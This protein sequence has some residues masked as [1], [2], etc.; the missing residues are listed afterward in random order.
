M[1]R[2]V[3]SREVEK[4]R[5]EVKPEVAIPSAPSLLDA[6]AKREWRRISVVLAKLELLTEI[7]RAALAM[8][9]TAY[10]RWWAAEKKVREHGQIMKGKSGALFQNPYLGIANRAFTQMHKML[11]EFGMTPSARAK[12]NV[13]D[14]AAGDEL[15]EFIAR[16][17]RRA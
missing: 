2:L 16:K 8:Y 17:S 7:D 6:E 15:G 11:V 12:L 4:R 3:G 1:L 10:S 13:L 5:R 9:C 14:K